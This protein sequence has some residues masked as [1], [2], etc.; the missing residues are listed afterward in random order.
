MNVFV[1]FSS[2]TV[3]QHQ[4]WNRGQAHQAYGYHPS[5][6][7]HSQCAKHEVADVV[8]LQIRVLQLKHHRPVS[9]H[10]EVSVL[11]CTLGYLGTTGEQPARLVA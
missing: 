9:Y 1:E 5:P 8:S 11:H 3:N 4:Y 6:A 10:A 2:L 7:D